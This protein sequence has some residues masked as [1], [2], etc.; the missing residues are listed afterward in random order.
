MLT[1]AV[2]GTS[3][4]LSVKSNEQTLPNMMDIFKDLPEQE[5]EAF[6][7]S[8]PMRKEN[9]GTVFYGAEDGSDLLFLLKAGRAQLYR[10][11]QDGK[12]LTLGIVEPGSIFGEMCLLDQGLAGTCAVAIE[13]SVVCALGRED[14]QKLV[15]DHPTVAL[16]IMEALARSL[17]QARNALEEMASSDVTG[18]VAGLLLRLADADNNLV[19]GYSHENLASMVGCL[20]ESFTATLNGL[21]RS[22]A[23]STGRKQIEVTDRK[24][25]ER[26]VS[27]RTGVRR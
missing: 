21:K 23:V 9:K 7:R 6:M 1:S 13:D 18:R 27:Q 12:K 8:A 10:Q 25:L 5:V 19:E 14:L 4:S 26:L 15:V 22:G 11:P 24:K 3:D 17:G 20:R 2:S 16:T